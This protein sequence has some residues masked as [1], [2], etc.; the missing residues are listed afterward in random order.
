MEHRGPPDPTLYFILARSIHDKT[1]G[2]SVGIEQIIIPGALPEKA[3][4]LGGTSR[5]ENDMKR[6]TILLACRSYF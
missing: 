3:V 1:R 2:D 4:Q 5:I 6:T